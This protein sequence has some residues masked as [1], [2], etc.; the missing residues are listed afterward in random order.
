MYARQKL[1]LHTSAYQTC[2]PM[3]IIQHY[4]H[5]KQISSSRNICNIFL[6]YRFQIIFQVFQ[7][8]NLYAPKEILILDEISEFK[9]VL[10]F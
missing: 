8:F 3:I 7:T 10:L 5:S 2:R 9:I 6:V 1:S 4:S